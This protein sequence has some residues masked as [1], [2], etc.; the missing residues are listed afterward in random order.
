MFSIL[1]WIKPATYALAFCA[2]LGV[3]WLYHSAEISDIRADVALERQE[4]A[5][6][7]QMVAAQAQK[8][9]AKIEQYFY[10]KMQ[11]ELADVPEPERVYIRA[12][13][14]AV[15]ATGNTGMDDGTRA[16]LSTSSKRLVSELRKRILRLENKLAAWQELAKKS[17]Q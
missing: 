12:S 7:S 13:C 5:E 4:Y 1:S 2:G 11:R 17:P 14:P 15:P 16:E 8:E 3:M 10:E 6:Q 9:V